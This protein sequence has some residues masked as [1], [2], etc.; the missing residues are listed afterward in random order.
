MESPCFWW[1]TRGTSSSKVKKTP[2]SSPPKA[3]MVMPR[4][5]PRLRFTVGSEKNA[6]G[7]TPRR[8]KASVFGFALDAIVTQGLMCCHSMKHSVGIMN[9]CRVRCHASSGCQARV[10]AALTAAWNAMQRSE[11]EA[12]E[13]GTLLLFR[14]QCTHLHAECTAVP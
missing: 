4:H 5:F 8:Q 11:T 9:D 12:R 6:S 2:M 14:M 13:T 10:Y 1:R 3:M 7:Q